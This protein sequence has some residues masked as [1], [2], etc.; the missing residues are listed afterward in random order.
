L[1][2]NLFTSRTDAAALLRHS[3]FL[4]AQ[5]RQWVRS[6]LPHVS[7]AD[8]FVTAREF[9]DIFAA[10]YRALRPPTSR[11]LLDQLVLADWLKCRYTFV[12][13]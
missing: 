9:R 7:S 13:M 6:L 12:S 3:P 8:A 11:A 1:K 5:T 10:L 2:F 4:R